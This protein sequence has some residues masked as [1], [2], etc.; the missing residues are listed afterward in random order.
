ML[1]FLIEINIPGS[2]EVKAFT[3]NGHPTAI[4]N[5]DYETAY[6]SSILRSMYPFYYHPITSIYG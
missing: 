3:L 1:D 2:L 6:F 5:N 4:T